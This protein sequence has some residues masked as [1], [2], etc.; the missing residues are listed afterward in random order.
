MC[1]FDSALQS[2]SSSLVTEDITE[3]RAKSQLV[4]LW[5]CCVANQGLLCS[6]WLCLS[7]FLQD[8]HPWL[9]YTSKQHWAMLVQQRCGS[10]ERRTKF[11]PLWA[12]S[13]TCEEWSVFHAKKQNKKK[14]KN[15]LRESIPS[16][17]ALCLWKTTAFS[18]C[19]TLG[20]ELWLNKQT[21]G[22]Q[23]LNK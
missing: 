16:G 5:G 20:V 4:S 21:A 7:K 11:H 17:W 9:P 3:A 1:L 13:Q 10:K 14:P 15:T 22:S 18:S 19:Q 12:C 6:G 23:R 8:R 2:V